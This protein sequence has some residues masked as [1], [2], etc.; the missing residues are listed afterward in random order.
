MTLNEIDSVSS[1]Q[2]RTGVGA[3]QKRASRAGCDGESSVRPTTWA[4]N[5]RL[6][7]PVSDSTW[8]EKE[9]PIVA[10]SLYRVATLGNP[11]LVQ[12]GP[13]R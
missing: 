1:Q 13:T 9:L 12:S 5:P 7:S 8:E 11:Q 3:H 6:T 4:P 2:T 10:R